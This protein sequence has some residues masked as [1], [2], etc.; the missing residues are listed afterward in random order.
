MTTTTQKTPAHYLEKIRSEYEALRDDLQAAVEN[1]DRLQRQREATATSAEEAG[2]KWRE[3]FKKAMGRPSEELR[4]LQAQQRTLE[5]EAAPLGELIGELEAQ[6]ADLTQKAAGTRRAYLARLRETRDRRVDAQLDGAAQEL[7]QSD[8]AAPFAEALAVRLQRVEADVLGDPAFMARLGFDAH[9]SV[10]TAF[11]AR[12]AGEDR[13]QIE[14]EVSR[15]R[16]RLVAE[17]VGRYLPR[18]VDVATAFGDDLVPMGRLECE[19]S[20]QPLPAG[21][22]VHAGGY[23]AEMMRMNMANARA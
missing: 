17:L 19:A 11:M 21:R 5:E 20:E 23:A 3:L 16:D 9:E 8:A 2:S 1:L 13:E 12:L 14:R 10:Q 6:V 15:R 7:L 22:Q 4:K 18:E